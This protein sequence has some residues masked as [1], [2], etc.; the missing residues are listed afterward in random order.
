MPLTE[1]RRIFWNVVFTYGRFL[2]SIAGGLFIIRWVLMA[3]GQVNYGL[4]SVIG[5]MVVFI[6]FFNNI[7]A[8]ATARFYAFSI[9]ENQ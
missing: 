3:L 8:S 7:L 2:L 1:N 9:G 4:F 6:Q 5:G